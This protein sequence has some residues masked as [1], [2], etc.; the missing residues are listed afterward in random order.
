MSEPTTRLDH[1]ACR[2]RVREIIH[3]AAG[4]EDDWGPW[5]RDVV[6]LVDAMADEIERLKY[7]IAK[8]TP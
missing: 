1:N 3:N 7:A 5:D 2:D 4:D 6:T 8:D